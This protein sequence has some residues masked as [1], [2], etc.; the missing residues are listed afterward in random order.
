M[1]ALDN[2]SVSSQRDG[3]HILR[4]KLK[5]PGIVLILNLCGS[6]YVPSPCTART[7]VAGLQVHGHLERQGKRVDGITLSGAWDG[8][9]WAGYADGSRK[10]LWKANPPYQP[11]AL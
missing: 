10:L 11:N 5:H 7:A 4:L 1:K 9:L 8:Q 3:Q 2:V 6:M